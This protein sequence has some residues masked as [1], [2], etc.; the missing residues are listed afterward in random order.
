MAGKTTAS[1]SYRVAA[2]CA[3]RHLDA[4]LTIE[5]RTLTVAQPGEHPKQFVVYAATHI[6]CGYDLRLFHKT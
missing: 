4:A 2:K 3:Q 6:T 5:Q 1:R